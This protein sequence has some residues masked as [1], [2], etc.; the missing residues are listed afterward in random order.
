MIDA[1]IAHPFTP[2]ALAMAAALFAFAV[3][4]EVVVFIRRLYREEAADRALRQAIFNAE[5]ATDE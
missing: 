5:D 2:K 3:F 4:V 1:I